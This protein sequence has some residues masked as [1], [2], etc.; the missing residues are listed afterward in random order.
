MPVYTFECDTCGLIFEV[1]RHINEKLS[2]I[3]CTNG[4]TQVHRV[5]SAPLIIFK[6]PGF[7]VNDNSSKLL[8]VDDDEHS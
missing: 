6:G 8:K 2:D 4:H 1:T 3:I 5:Y 7:Y